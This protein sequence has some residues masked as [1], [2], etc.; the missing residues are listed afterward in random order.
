MDEVRA[1][2]ARGERA[3]CGLAHLL[4][5]APNCTVAARPYGPTLVAVAK[6]KAWLSAGGAG[7]AAVGSGA[8]SRRRCQPAAMHAPRP[9]TCRPPPPPTGS[10]EGH[11]CTLAWREELSMPRLLAALLGAFLFW[12]APVLSESTPFR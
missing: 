12:Y 9:P 2:Y 3:W 8:V 10:G 1:A 6:P 4:N 7:H 5:D 11:A